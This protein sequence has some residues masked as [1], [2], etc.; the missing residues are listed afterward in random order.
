[1]IKLLALAASG[2]VMVFLAVFSPL[3]EIKNVTFNDDAACIKNSQK[4]A[5]DNLI[6]ESLIFLNSQ[7][8]AQVIKNKFACIETIDVNR[9]FP[10]TV[11]INIQSKRPIAKIAE[12]EFHV[13]KDG[14][15]IRAD[16]SVQIPTIFLPTNFELNVSQK[17]DDKNILFAL[18]I[19]DN[20]LK[21]DF[22]PTT[23]RIVDEDQ[24]AVYSNKDI[25]V[26]FSSNKNP[27]SQ[28]DS[29]Q[30][31]LAEAKIDATKIGK[32]DMRFEK[33]VISSKK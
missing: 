13:T 31:I 29:L 32:I 33:P 10:S 6:G 15:L 18:E 25:L 27:I 16:D 22:V 7:E 28:V 3:F 24:I 11:Q 1:V 17:L 30:L 19:I 5:E 21:S 2:F 26:L 23:I 14:L 20:L 9:Q 12:T 8:I 4:I